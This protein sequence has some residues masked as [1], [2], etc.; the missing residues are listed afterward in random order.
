MYFDSQE[1]I[2]QVEKSSS[3]RLEKEKTEGDSG[4]EMLQ[5]YM[6]NYNIEL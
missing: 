3:E 1:E 2:D 5:L 6:K 4:G